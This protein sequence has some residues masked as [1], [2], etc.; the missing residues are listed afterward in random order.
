METESHVPERRRC[1]RMEFKNRRILIFSPPPRVPV[2]LF[3]Y[4]ISPLCASNLQNELV[5][6]YTCSVL[7]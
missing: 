7:C 5:S 4:I 6:K 3:Q 1:L 2:K